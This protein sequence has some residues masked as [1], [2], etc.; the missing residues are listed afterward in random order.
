MKT[1]DTGRHPLLRQFA[2]IRFLRH[3]AGPFGQLF[4]E[5]IIYWRHIRQ[6]EKPALRRAIIQMIFS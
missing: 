4:D 5:R 6:P 1:A 2:R 3:L